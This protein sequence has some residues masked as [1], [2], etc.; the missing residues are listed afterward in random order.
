MLD[1]PSVTVVLPQSIDTDTVAFVIT[2]QS[3]KN[4]D[5]ERN[6]VSAVKYPIRDKFWLE[7]M[8]VIQ[9]VQAHIF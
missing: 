5:Y 2:S 4:G 1:S 3:N 7:N 8:S 9:V 6:E